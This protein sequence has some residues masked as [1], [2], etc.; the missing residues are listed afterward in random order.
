MNQIK[1]YNMIFPFWFLLI[2]PITWLIILPA[3]FILD[4]LLLVIFMKIVKADNIIEEYKKS[5][6]KVWIFGFL[7]D[8]IGCIPLIFMAFSEIG[9]GTYIYDSLRDGIMMKPVS[10]IYSF[11][12][13]LVCVVISAILIYF[14]DYKIT[15]KNTKLSDIQKKK[16]AILMAVFTAPYLFFLPAIG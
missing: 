4:S 5:I 9:E 14:F 1:I 7:A 2:M 12:F 15:L 16:T 6:V 10:N 11:M 13:T 3:N 8:I